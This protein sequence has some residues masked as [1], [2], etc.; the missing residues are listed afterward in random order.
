MN[1]YF[2][3]FNVH[4]NEMNKARRVFNKRFGKGSYRQYIGPYIR[5]GIM[6][7]FHDTPTE[8]TKFYVNCISRL[9]N[10]RLG[11]THEDVE[12]Q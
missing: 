4:K 3:V 9:V 2:A 7:I 10:A 11:E 1:F 12:T 5:K 8:H 6:S